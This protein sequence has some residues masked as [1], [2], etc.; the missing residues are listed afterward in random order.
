MRQ[1]FVQLLMARFFV[2]AN[3]RVLAADGIETGRADLHMTQA[4]D[5]RHEI[6]DAVIFGG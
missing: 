3:G 6:P 2:A 5:E 4:G 1:C